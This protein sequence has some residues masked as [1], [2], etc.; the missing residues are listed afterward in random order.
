MNNSIVQQLAHWLSSRGPRLASAGV[1]FTNRIPEP[2][3]S[4]PWKGGV[5]LVKDDILV[6]FTVWERTIFQTELI[7]VDGASGETLVSKDA[8]PE[9]V[10]DIDE[11]LDSIVDGLIGGTYRRG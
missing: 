11:V 4:V 8:T 6:S 1:E 10:E 7:I 5:G 2:S 9:N 3:S